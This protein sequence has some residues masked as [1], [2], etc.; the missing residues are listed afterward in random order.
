MLAKIKARLSRLV[1]ASEVRHDIGLFATALIATGVF[2]RGAPLSLGAL[3]SA[4]I[5]AV[6]RAVVQRLAARARKAS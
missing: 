6:R 3:S 4:V 2:D 5:V 1:R